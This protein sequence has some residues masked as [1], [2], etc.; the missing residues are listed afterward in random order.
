MT[1]EAAMRRAV[2]LSRRGYPAPNPHV[3][4][5][6]VRDGKVVGEGFHAFAGGEHAEAVALRKAG[7]RARGSHAYVTLEPC[8]H[9]GRTPP[10]A[11]ALV[12]AEVASVSV[13]VPDPNPVAAGGADFLRASG[14]AVDVGLLESEARAANEVWLTA[15]A[16]RRPWVT[17]KAGIGLDGRIAL[18]DGQSQWITGDEARR[19]AHRLR[20]QMGAVLVG[21]DTVL[22]DDPRMDVRLP[23]VRRQPHR[24]VADYHGR[25][26]EDRRM[27][28]LPG[29]FRLTRQPER[30]YDLELG[31]RSPSA[32]L[33]ALW[34]NGE[35]SVLL[36]GG[37]RLIGAFLEADLVDRVVLYLAPKILGAGI[38]WAEAGNLRDPLGSRPWRFGSVARKGTDLRVVLEREP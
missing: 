23:R 12:Q 36:E 20:L 24:Y 16:L 15:Q 27:F 8:N 10:C 38:S 31:E 25:V 5:V 13:A 34:A 9:Y 1:P 33:D 6:L 17:V 14:V 26:P 3:G 28:T 37:G 4:C 35:T 29:A 2:A 22:A 11:R 32:M 19:D 30:R 7:E 21:A 18:P